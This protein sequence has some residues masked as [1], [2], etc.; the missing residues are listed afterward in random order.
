MKA[1]LVD[2]QLTTRLIVSDDETED[3]I[4]EKAVYRLIQKI[5]SGEWAE[6]MQITDDVECPY[7]PEFV[8]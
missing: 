8:I 2:V 3:S 4:I 1:V 5:E 6:S 7:D